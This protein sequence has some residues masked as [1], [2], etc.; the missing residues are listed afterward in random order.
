H[1]VD[2]L[3]HFVLK[4]VSSKVILPLLFALTALVGFFLADALGTGH[5]LVSAL[6]SSHAA[7]YM[8]LLLFLLRAIGMMFSNTSGVTGGV[9]LPTLAFGAILGALCA[10]GMIALGWIGAEYYMLMIVLGIASFLGAT[11]RIPLTACVFAVETLG[12]I[13]TVLPI[14]MATTVALLIVEA[15]GL[16]DF[17]DTVINAKM[18]KLTKNKK[19]LTVEVPLTVALHSF[20]IDKELRDILWPNSCVVLSYSH[21]EWQPENVGIAAGDVITVRYVTYDPAATAKE[22][23]ALVGEQSEEAMRLMLP[24]LS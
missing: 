2:H 13:H 17:T 1:L 23:K 24:T 14:V 3:M 16:E 8:L 18:R 9:F 20:A 4:R 6:L 12:G 21:A 19:P 11:S 10:K 15:T 22:L 5:S 7:W